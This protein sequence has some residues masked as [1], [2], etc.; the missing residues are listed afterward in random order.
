MRRLL[1]LGP[2]VLAL[3][4]LPA[5]TARLDEPRVDP[6]GT[7]LIQIAT[8]KVT[9]CTHGS[10]RS[11]RDLYGQ[12]CDTV[13]PAVDPLL[14]NPL[15]CKLPYLHHAEAYSDQAAD[16]GNDTHR[17]ELIYLRNA[18]TRDTYAADSRTLISAYQD[19]DRFLNSTAREEGAAEAHLRT[20]TVSPFDC[21]IRVVDA[22]AD[23]GDGSYGAIVRAAQWAGY[24]PDPGRDYLIYSPDF[25][26]CGTANVDPD[27]NPDPSRNANNFDA[28]YAVIGH[29]SGCFTGHVVLHELSHTLG[30]VQL[31]A[32]HSTGG[33][34]CTDGADVMC[35]AD[36]GPT[37]TQHTV[38]GAERYD[39]GQDDY[40]AVRPRG[41]YL[42][43]HWNLRDSYF[44]DIR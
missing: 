30:A 11:P 15:I 13:N 22:V 10:D 8:L 4:A 21:T 34:H 2:V 38:C 41:G 31:G 19:A 6:C 44:I 33:W 14:A 26:G 9:L 1:L 24:E 37:D 32:P 20:L 17:V 18:A 27:S 29:L 28:K 35:Y 25:T 36:G 40:F 42:P 23:T 12:E 7:G 43:A 39:C 16:C 5:L 3:A